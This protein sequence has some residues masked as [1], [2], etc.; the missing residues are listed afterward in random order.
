MKI[1]LIALTEHGEII[2]SKLAL[3][4]KE[5]ADMFVLGKSRQKISGWKHFA[6]K[7]VNLNKKLLEQYELLI[8][9]M[10]VDVVVR[11]FLGIMETNK[12]GPDVLVIDETGKFVVSLLQ[13]HLEES[14]VMAG[15]IAQVIGGT[16]VITDQVETCPN[17]NLELLARHLYCKIIHQENYS[18]IKEIIAQNQRIDIFT[19]LALSLAPCD[20][21]KIF[22]LSHYQYKKDSKAQGIIFITN[23]IIPPP[24]DKPYLILV[25]KNIIVG[26]ECNKRSTR[27]SVIKAIWLAL[28]NKRIDIQSLAYLAVEEGKK[29]WSVFQEVCRDLGVPLREIK[30]EKLT[31]QRKQASWQESLLR[32]LGKGKTSEYLAL[33]VKKDTRL[34]VPS[35]KIGGVEVAVSEIQ[36][37]V[38]TG[39]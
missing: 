25:P 20:Y 9:I 5:T 3:H 17:L 8:Y 23:R 1:A 29:E 7:L 35:R 30:K 33:S 2:A 27:G 15:Q 22:P 11:S 31:E 39:F 6:G 16:A 37:S 26:V 13:G 34:V 19:N 32:A 24:A 12:P 4:F 10:P 38:E 14:N 36:L 28:E 18:P 21:L